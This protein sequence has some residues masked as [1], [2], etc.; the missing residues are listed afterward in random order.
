M[1]CHNISYPTAFHVDPVH[2]V[3]YDSDVTEN[4]NE[5]FFNTL[6]QTQAPTVDF[7]L[8]KEYVRNTF[9]VKIRWLNVPFQRLLIHDVENEL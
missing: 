4:S 3:F 5:L 1:T 7:Q 6:E 8:L 2:T 9:V